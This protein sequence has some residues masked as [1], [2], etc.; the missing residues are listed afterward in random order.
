MAEC[1]SYP[2]VIE[3]SDLVLVDQRVEFLKV[4]TDFPCSVFVKICRVFRWWT[5]FLTLH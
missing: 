2:Y 3:F 5:A 1:S 4:I